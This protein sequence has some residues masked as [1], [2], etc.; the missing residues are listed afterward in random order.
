MTTDSVLVS[1][2]QLSSMMGAEPVVIID[3]RDAETYAAGHLPGA[4]NMR[5]IFTF[6][7]T[8]TAEGLTALKSTFA[9]HFG[10]VGLSGAE[11]A[12][13]YEDALN[14]GYGQ[15]CRGYYLL[16]WLGYPKIK[17]LNGGFSAWK[18][19]GLPV[20]VEGATPKV[21][22]FP[23]DLAMSDVMLTKDDVAAALNTGIAL[24][25]VR[26][27]DEWT[28]ESSSPYGKDFAP[29][30]GRLPGAKWIEWY[31]FMK[32]SAQGPVF[33]SPLEVQAE[34]A[35]AGI[36]TSD[37]VY[38]YCFKGARASNTFLA[39][40]QAGFSDVRMYFGSWNEWSRDDSLPI[41]TEAPVIKPRAPALALAA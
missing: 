21:A 25:D 2:E 31:R 18:A 1:P 27:I 24:L 40:K 12:V 5:E 23:T 11:T 14:S 8:S 22:A 13:F 6:L 17:V 39:L 38:L 30:K 7:A 37:T 9:E 32:P 19:Q 4:V 15:S 28:G 33:K 36:S 35:T 16:T 10:A 29:R 26:D 41:E 34:C 20:S 3:T